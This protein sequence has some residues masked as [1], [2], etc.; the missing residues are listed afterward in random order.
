MHFYNQDIRNLCIRT[1]TILILVFY[2][3][4]PDCLSDLAYVIMNAICKLSYRVSNDDVV[5]ACNQV[6]AHSPASYSFSNGIADEC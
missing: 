5:R 1:V 6:F 2:L 3:L 4:Q